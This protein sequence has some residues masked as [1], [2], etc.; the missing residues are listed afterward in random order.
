[1]YLKINIPDIRLIPFDRLTFIVPLECL[2]SYENKMHVNK[3][4]L[5]KYNLKQNVY[6]R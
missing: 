6:A 3:A 2:L 4:I 1:M 5:F